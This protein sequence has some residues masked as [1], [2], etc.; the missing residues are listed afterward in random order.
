MTKLTRA[1]RDRI[2]RA[3]VTQCVQMRWLTMRFIYS[4][5]CHRKAISQTNHAERA[6]APHGSDPTLST[7]VRG[8]PSIIASLLFSVLRGVCGPTDLSVGLGRFH[9][10]MTLEMC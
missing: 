10:Q 1:G 5:V 4:N 7:P 8:L 6:N 9:F 2:K 3:D